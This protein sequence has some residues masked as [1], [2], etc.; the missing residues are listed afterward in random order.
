MSQNLLKTIGIIAC[1]G[2]LPEEIASIYTGNGGKCFI[3]LI[4]NNADPELLF[5]YSGKNFTL[6]QVGA[7]IDYFKSENIEDIIMIGAITRPDFLSLKVD[8]IGSKLV[9]NILKNKFLGDDN[10]LKT[11]SN[12]LEKQGFE[13]ISPK[14]ILPLADYSSNY[15]TK[16]SLSKQ[17]Q[18][19]IEIGAKVLQSLGDVDVGQSVIVSDGYV[20][21]IEAAEGTDN[22]I[23]RC[24]LLRKNK[25]GGV[26][27]KSSKVSQDKRLDIPTIGPET[28]FCL[29]KHN[30]HGVAIEKDMVIVV[31]PKETWELADK[32]DL[33]IHFIK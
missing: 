25:N 21:G 26:L 31:S 27:I 24:D 16:K 32:Y 4:E 33:F 5:K 23:R 1:G 12:F 13:I 20:L 6:G 10:L 7:M 18:I 14:E 22:L 30:F 11:V 8:L 15:K 29:A 9:A 3:A 17:D 2:K 19:D 28:I